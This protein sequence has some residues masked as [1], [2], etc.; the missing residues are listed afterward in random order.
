MQNLVFVKA[1]PKQSVL[2]VHT[3]VDP[4]S[5]K[6]LNKTKI[7]NTTD[8]IVALYNTR[9]KKLSNYVSTTPWIEEGVVKRDSTGKELTLQQKLEME[10]N[11]PK[12]Y[13]T[14]TA[15]TNDSDFY[16]GKI[17]PTYYQTASWEMQDGTT[18]FD[19]TK[20][21]DLLGYYVCLSHKLVA[22][23]EKEWKQHKWPNAQYYISI[24]NE[25]EE[26]NYKTNQVKVEA[27]TMLHSEDMTPLA[28]RKMAVLL[29][30]ISAKAQLTEIHIDN[31]LFSFIDKADS[32]NLSDV[33]RFKELFKMM[34]TPTGK[35]EFEAKFLLEKA[36]AWRVINEKH[37][38]YTWIRSKGSIE[39]G[40]KPESAVQF[41]MNPAKKDLIEEL[42]KEI[43]LK[44]NEE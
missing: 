8:R 31:L 27:F 21:D 2:G 5:G 34:T 30:L 7:G 39:L 26:V 20:L 43:R 18:V 1:I 42:E 6:P 28:K 41:L 13:L 35:I 40:A 9:T 10:W 15:I 36:L 23:S 25:M 22:N 17:T 4:N 24:E 44:A 11:L 29:K 19:L 16:A 14:D 3:N 33:V 38:T 12:D 37:G 32:K